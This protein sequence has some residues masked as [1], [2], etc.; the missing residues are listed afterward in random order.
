MTVGN[1]GSPPW[2]TVDDTGDWLSDEANPQ[3][4]AT[5]GKWVFLAAPGSEKGY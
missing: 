2:S 3:G 1:P 4:V 5:D